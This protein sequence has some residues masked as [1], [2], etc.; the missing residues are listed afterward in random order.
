MDI[1]G[2][3]WKSYGILISSDSNEPQ[4]PDSL[5]FVSVGI[6]TQKALVVMLEVAMPHHIDSTANWPTRQER[7]RSLRSWAEKA[8]ASRESHH[9]S[10]PGINAPTLRDCS[11][12]PVIL[13]CP[14]VQ[15]QWCYS[16][17]LESR[18]TGA[19][20]YTRWEIASQNGKQ[21]IQDW[22][23]WHWRNKCSPAPV[24]HP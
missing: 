18:L 1:Y 5:N 9:Q 10:T 24:H 7:S 11:M 21:L 23:Y 17:H 3:I 6:L 16:S 19:I 12:I 4:Q 14:M 15:F 20:S 2:R 8:R 22:I 13:R